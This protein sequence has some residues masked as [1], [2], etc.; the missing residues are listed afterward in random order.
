MPASIR[1]RSCSRSE[2]ACG[3]RS[4]RSRTWRA[5]RCRQAATSDGKKRIRW[6][7]SRRSDGWGVHP[8]RSGGT[9][10]VS[11]SA[12]QGVKSDFCCDPAFL[13]PRSRPATPPGHLQTSPVRPTDV[14]S[15][16]PCPATDRAAL[17]GGSILGIRSIIGRRQVQTSDFSCDLVRMDFQPVQ[18]TSVKRECQAGSSRRTVIPLA[19][20]L[21]ACPPGAVSTRTAR[22]L[23]P[24]AEPEGTRGLPGSRG[25]CH[26]AHAGRGDRPAW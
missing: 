3:N 21:A 7:K 23:Y 12:V 4:L 14:R 15:V 5:S 1:S 25:R 20:S 2:G 16:H 19:T 6:R 10:L 26:R 18:C 13:I 9:G 17:T 24:A 11:P 22:F 8:L